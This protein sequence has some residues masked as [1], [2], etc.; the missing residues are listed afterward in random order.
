MT[1]HPKTI[2]PDALAASGVGMM[3]DHQITQLVIIDGDGLPVGIVH[4][5]DLLRAK[6]V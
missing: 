6:V 4:L 5:H 1:E 3:E 2:K